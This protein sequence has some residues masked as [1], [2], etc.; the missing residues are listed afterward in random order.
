METRHRVDTSDRGWL[1]SG[2]RV[3]AHL[4][5]AMA[6]AGI[7][8]SHA[9]QEAPAAAPPAAQGRADMTVDSLSVVKVRSKALANARS[10][11]A[12]GTQREG[13]GVVIDSDGLVLTIGYLIT[14]AETV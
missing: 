3:A 11:R 13:T 2:L 5:F 8:I 6:A 14:E 7:G 1:R 4:A 10:T 12:L 9:A